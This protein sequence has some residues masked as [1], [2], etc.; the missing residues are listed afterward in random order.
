MISARTA[1]TPEAQKLAVRRSLVQFD[2]MPCGK[3]NQWRRAPGLYRAQKNTLPRI[4]R[5]WLVALLARPFRHR[6]AWSCSMLRGKLPS[7]KRLAAMWGGP[8]G[9]DGVSDSSVV[10]H[11]AIKCW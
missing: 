5:G 7:V 9:L 10:T 4:I 3:L 2:A 11:S 6:P 8:T 1:G